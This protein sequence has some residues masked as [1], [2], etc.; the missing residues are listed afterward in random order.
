MK[1]AQSVSSSVCQQQKFSYFLTLDFSD[2]L[3]Q[4]S[5]QQFLEKWSF[6]IFDEIYFGPKTDQVY[7]SAQNR[8]FCQFSQV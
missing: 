2:I 7:K 4:V 3:H 5:L 1:P 8:G 6:W